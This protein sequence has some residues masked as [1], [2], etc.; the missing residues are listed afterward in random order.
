MC[1][2]NGRMA[3]FDEKE[4]RIMGRTASGVKGIN[5]VN[6]ICVGTEVSEDN[7]LLLVVTENGYGKKTSISEYRETK[8][9]SKGVK[10]INLSEKSGKV[11]GFKSTDND[12]DLMI[13]TE[14]GII[15]RMDVNNISEMGRVTKGVKLINLKNNNKV[16]SISIINKELN[17]ENE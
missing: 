2:S 11:I 5:L 3:R 15:I 8:R 6:D 9:G 16:A 12:K 4:V 7:K 1:S 17:E 13:I 10:T 14:N